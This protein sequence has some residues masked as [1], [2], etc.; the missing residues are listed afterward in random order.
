LCPFAFSTLNEQ[1]GDQQGLGCHQQHHEEDVPPLE[2]PKRGSPEQYEA[3]RQDPL[4][5]TL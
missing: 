2:F 1:K 3:A 5:T 4:V